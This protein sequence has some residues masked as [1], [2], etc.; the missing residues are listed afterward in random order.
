[1]LSA[2]SLCGL[3]CLS[4]PVPAAAPEPAN[5]ESA[6]GVSERQTARMRAL[7]DA[8]TSGDADKAE[9]AWFPEKPFVKLK[10]VAKPE[11]YWAN[12]RDT[13]RKDVLK[14]HAEEKDW[15]DSAFV[16]FELGSRPTWVKPGQEAN[17]TGY[18]RSYRSR[19][20]YR[21]GDREK[22]LS[23]HVMITEGGEWYVT[24]L[25]RMKH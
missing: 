24:H 18:F 11:K 16:R 1:M 4:F 12:L 3:F 9:P 23:V 8:I 2:L 19:I 13:F 6:P 14:L 22:S 15:A 20:V 7:F 17:K 21:K 25:K 10:D 5:N